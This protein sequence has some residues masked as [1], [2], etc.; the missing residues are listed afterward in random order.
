MTSA[1]SNFWYDEQIKNYMYQFMAIFSDLHVR[2][3]KTDKRDEALIPVDMHYGSK[4]RVVGSII[5][6]NTQNKPIRLPVM[7]TYISNI[8][9]EPALRKGIGTTQRFTHLPRG[10][11]LPDDITTVERYM[12]V[13]YKLE[14]ELGIFT[15]SQDQH[16]QILEQIL[17]V[18]DP[19]VQ[20]Q[21]SDA[22]FDWTKITTV[23]L[24]NIRFD[25][26]YP[27][28]TDRRMIQTYLDFQFPIYLSPPA[29][30]RTSFVE[31]ILMRIG[32]IEAGVLPENIVAEFDGLGIE[33]EEIASAEDFEDKN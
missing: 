29:D 5:A 18:F 28:G 4:D 33:Y 6:G 13:P 19:I 22:P 12:P 30:V 11:L 16:M 32:A 25:E 10:G 7:S 2:V 21:K 17:T 26:N 23:E 20:I 14:V 8:A 24:T 27:M 1:V 9:L 31:R 3:G 15:S